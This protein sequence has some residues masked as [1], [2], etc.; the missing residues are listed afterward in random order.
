MFLVEVA[1][2]IYVVGLADLNLSYFSDNG[3]YPVFRI[4]FLD[5][6]HAGVES[7]KEFSYVCTFVHI[8]YNSNDVYT[9]TV[10]TNDTYSAFGK[11]WIS[12]WY[13]MVVLIIL[14]VC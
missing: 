7:L 13:N 1:V 2:L 4:F 3:R 12:I 11:K 10:K 6:P 9:Y 14:M 5:T 8:C